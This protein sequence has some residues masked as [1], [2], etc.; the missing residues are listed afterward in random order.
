MQLLTRQRNPP[1]APRF[2][3]SSQNAKDVI[4]GGRAAVNYVRNTGPAI[5]QVH[6]YRFNGHSPADPEHERGRKDEKKWA[7]KEQDP[8]K[9]FEDDVVKRG[10]IT[11]EV[12]MGTLHLH[13]RSKENL[14]LQKSWGHCVR[15]RGSTATL[16]R[17]VRALF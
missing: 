5:L 8:I 16:L 6:T 17:L 13:L 7:R 15:G 3:P 2:P 9:I 14:N 4:K 11:E 1:S 10:V 12:R